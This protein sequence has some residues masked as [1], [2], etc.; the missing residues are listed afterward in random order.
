MSAN[1]THS[2]DYYDEKDR[3]MLNCINNYH[4]AMTYK[5]IQRHA[6]GIHF[7]SQ[8]QYGWFCDTCATMSKPLLS[9]LLDQIT[10]GF[11]VT[12]SQEIFS[13][14]GYSR[15]KTWGIEGGVS[16]KEDVEISGLKW[17]K[18]EFLEVLK[19]KLSGIS[20]GLGFWPWKFYGVS[21]NFAEFP[22]VKNCSPEFRKVKWKILKFR[23]LGFQKTL[24]S[25]PPSWIFWNR[26]M[27]KWV[28]SKTLSCY[29]MWKP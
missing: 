29:F 21:H 11:S 6:F 20:M 23:N 12:I 5:E 10:L 3:S 2:D 8:I 19:K 27:D 1:V 28:P 14:M 15:R 17:K 9:M 26:P 25:T 4:S 7:T 24:F 16:K 18:V 22:M 13:A